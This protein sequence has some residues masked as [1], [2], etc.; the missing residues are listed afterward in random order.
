MNKPVKHILKDG[1]IEFMLDD[2]KLHR[3]DGP[4]VIHSDGT[5]EWYQNG[6][7]HRTDGPAIES[8][9]GIYKWFKNGK[10]HRTDGPAIIYVN[11]LIEYWIDGINYDPVTFLIKSYEL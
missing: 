8:P 1:T 2:G 7:L 6:V 9:D 11:N 10:N 4:A 3:T 5:R